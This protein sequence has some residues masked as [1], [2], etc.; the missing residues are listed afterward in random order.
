VVNLAFA[1]APVTFL[2]TYDERAF[3]AEVVDDARRTHPE[4]VRATGASASPAYRE[5][6]EF[7]VQPPTASSAMAADHRT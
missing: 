6:G 2:C 5:P 1:S 7:L 3:P 4:V